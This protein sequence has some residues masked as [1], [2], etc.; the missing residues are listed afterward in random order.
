MKK[1]IYGGIFLSLFIA[2]CKKDDADPSPQPG[3]TALYANTAA[4]SSW[5]Y[6]DTDTSGNPAVIINTTLSTTRDTT[7]AGVSYHVYTNTPSGDI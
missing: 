7:V 3:A 2:G 5:R 1:L 4:G 6:Q